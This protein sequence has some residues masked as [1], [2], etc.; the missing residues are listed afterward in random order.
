MTDTTVIDDLYKQAREAKAPVTAPAVEA[1]PEVYEAAPNVP[2]AAPAK[3]ADVPAAEAKT[4][5]RAWTDDDKRAIIAELAKLKGVY[6][7]IGKRCV[8]LGIAQSTVSLWRRQLAAS[9]SSKPKRTAAARPSP[10]R[11]KAAA[12]PARLS[13]ELRQAVARAVVGTLCKA[14]SSVVVD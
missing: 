6:G 9:G 1:T 11:A 4:A 14:L 10:K 12:A 13:P 3:A 2:D 7:A 5:R 8:E